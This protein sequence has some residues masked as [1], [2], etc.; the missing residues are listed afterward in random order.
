MKDIE[1]FRSLSLGLYREGSSYIYRLR[2]VTKYVWLLALLIAAIL[3][4]SYAGAILPFIVVLVLGRLGAGIEISFFLRGLKPLV[5]FILLAGI[6]QFFFSWPGDR[7]PILFALGPFAL[8]MLKLRLILIT[9]LR[10][11]SVMAVLSLFTSITSESESIHGI[12]DLLAPLAK[13]GISPDQL[14]LAIGVA[15]RFVPLLALELETIAK[16]QAARGADFGRA[17]G[18]PLARARAYLPLIVPVTV[19]ALERAESMAEAMTVRGFGDVSR[20]GRKTRLVQYQ[21]QRGEPFV[22]VLGL[23]IAIL[24]FVLDPLVKLVF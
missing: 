24:S 15:L 2:P 12:E 23:A 22:I 6:I 19:R 3:A 8:T 1:L 14:S 10:A 17:K 16:A 21:A 5:P 4:P 9:A 13:L 7:S 11:L 20:R 18:G